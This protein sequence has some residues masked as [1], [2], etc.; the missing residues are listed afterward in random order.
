METERELS[1]AV[2][3]GKCGWVHFSVTRKYA[4]EAVESFNRY[5]LNCTPEQKE[6]FG[7][8]G[9]NLAPY[10]S[11]MLCGS[12]HTEFRDSKDGDCPDGCTLN[13]ILHYNEV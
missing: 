6:H 3:C 9:A 7:G 10:L 4:E 1:G 2:T 5:F 8:K 11:C 12:P 13:P